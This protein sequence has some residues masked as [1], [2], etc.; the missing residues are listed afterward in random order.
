MEHLI[1]QAIVKKCRS[2][3]RKEEK[4]RYILGKYRSKHQ[5][6]TGV[7]A[8]A[9]Q[10]RVPSMWSVSSH[11]DPRY[12]LKNSEFLARVLWS[13]IQEG[14]YEPAPAVQVEIPKPN[15]EKRIIMVFSIPDAAVANVMF[16]KLRAYAHLNESLGIPKSGLI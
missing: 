16:G 5:L 12:C 8:K 7:A 2:L 1:H 13:R 10:F 14:K 15:G 11:F 6:R 9:T 3:L 4:R